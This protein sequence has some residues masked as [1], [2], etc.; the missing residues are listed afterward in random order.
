MYQYLT[1]IIDNYADQFHFSVDVRQQSG[2]T[3]CVWTAC[4][5]IFTSRNPS[6]ECVNNCVIFICIQIKLTVNNCNFED[7]HSRSANS[8]KADVLSP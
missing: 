5:T 1:V 8:A 4:V 3:F 6:L 2:L 7:E